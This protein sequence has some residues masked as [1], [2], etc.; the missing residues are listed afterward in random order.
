MSTP[1]S[2]T[3]CG[4]TLGHNSRPGRPL[5]VLAQPAFKNRCLNPYN[6]LLSHALE[7]RGVH[8]REFSR[9]LLLTGD[10]DIWHLHW[11]EGTV[12]LNGSSS[13]AA[14]LRAAALIVLLRWARWRGKRIVWTVHNL[15]SHERKHP[16]LEARFW[17]AYTQLVDGFI[18]LSDYGER[19]VRA[20]FPALRRVPGFVIPHGHYRDV[21][22]D[23]LS[24]PA[25]RERLGLASGARITV[26]VGQI[27]QY[28]NVST[29]ITEFR[30][31]GDPDAMLLIAGSPVDEQLAG[32]LRRASDGDTRIRLALRLLSEDELQ[33]YVSAAD[34]VVLPYRETLN[35]GS[36]VLALSLNRPILV[37]RIGALGELQSLVGREWV[38]T[39]D[40]ELT[41]SRLQE[42]L[43]WAIESTRAPVAPLHTME[44]GRIAC[45][46][47]AAYTDILASCPGADA[48]SGRNRPA[49]VRS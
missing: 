9:E 21:Y 6:W 26:Y 40:G 30:R 43:R 35:S 2:G 25:A 11:P 28:K 12:R 13:R 33:G 47:A 7:A 41:A 31:L 4:S 39:Y 15:G 8:V 45:A 48:D 5:R 38:C 29:L 1:R 18:A 3:E 23:P 17:S 24:H 34:L 32:E 37:P 16:R 10:D 14:A 46:T 22:T 20:R 19:A 44:W 49:L 27:R 42:A 36:A